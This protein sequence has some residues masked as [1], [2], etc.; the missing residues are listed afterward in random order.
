MKIASRKLASPRLVGPPWRPE[1]PEESKDGTN[2][3]NERTAASDRNRLG[4][5]SRPR[6]W[7]ARIAPTPG[8]EAMM[9]V[10]SA[11]A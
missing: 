3:L 5:P 1:S 11:L 9:P 4:S 7:A 6:I 8:A 2:P 10:G